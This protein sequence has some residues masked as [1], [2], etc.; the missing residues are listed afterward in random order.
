MALLDP[1]DRV[2]EWKSRDHRRCT[3]EPVEHPIDQFG[4]REWPGAVMDQHALGAM[5]GQGFKAEPYRVLP[6]RATRRRWQDRDAGK[7]SVEDRAILRPDHD[8]DTRNPR[9]AGERRNRVPQDRD[10][11]S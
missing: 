8:H 10:R 4:A 9:M 7:R 5:L 2:A 3:V 11:K 1:L 6:L